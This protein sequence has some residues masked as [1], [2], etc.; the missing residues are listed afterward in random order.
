LRIYLAQLFSFAS[1]TVTGAVGFIGF[2]LSTRLLELG[3]PVVGFDDVTPI[4][5]LL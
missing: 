3:T 5:A 2:Y 4:V 1:M